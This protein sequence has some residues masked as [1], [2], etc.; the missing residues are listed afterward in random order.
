MTAVVATVMAAVV[1]FDN[2]HCLLTSASAAA[3][4]AAKDDAYHNDPEKCS[5]AAS[6]AFLVRS[7]A[8]IESAAVWALISVSLIV[9]STWASYDDQARIVVAAPVATIITS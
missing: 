3:S 8:T 6:R 1:F 2:S 4:A 7:A 5:R 9:G